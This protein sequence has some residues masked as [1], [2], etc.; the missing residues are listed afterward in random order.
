MRH[1]PFVVVLICLSVMLM[2]LIMFPGC[3]K[4]APLPNPPK[5]A[6]TAEEPDKPAVAAPFQKFAAATSGTL[7]AASA[8]KVGDL[9]IPGV[10]LLGICMAVWFL[11]RSWKT[12][13]LCFFLGGASGAFAVLLTDYPKVVLLIPL[14]GLAFL[15]GCAVKT[16]I[17][18]WTGYQA[19]KA[20]STEIEV[21]DTG[22]RSLGQ[23]VKD[24]F[25]E[26]GLTPIL[27]KALKMM[28]KIW[29]KQPP[30]SNA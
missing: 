3:R 24:R 14:C 9:H 21:A 18:W 23:L 13:L 10:V 2:A 12:T 7:S 29:S 27:E 19:W 8:D 11:T 30:K 25:A 4:N 16:T 5:D 26:A 20:V 17:E 6:A 15:I 22:K 28:E 1:N